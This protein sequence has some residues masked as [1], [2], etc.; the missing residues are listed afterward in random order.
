MYV[1]AK[2]QTFS[3]P[4]CGVLNSGREPMRISVSE[5]TKRA[6]TMSMT[7]R[8]KLLFFVGTLKVLNINCRRVLDSNISC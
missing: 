8:L 6:E 1:L 3:M 4:G 5:A 2:A 7:T